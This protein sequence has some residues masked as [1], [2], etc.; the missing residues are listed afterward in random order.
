MNYTYTKTCSLLDIFPKKEA[1]QLFPQGH[2]CLELSCTNILMDPRTASDDRNV[3]TLSVECNKF[4]DHVP[5]GSAVRFL[6]AAVPRFWYKRY[7]F[8]FLVNLIARS[9]DDLISR[10]NTNGEDSDH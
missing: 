2:P 1:K 4:V 3:I 10:V 7:V 9:C 8:L 5:A 6:H